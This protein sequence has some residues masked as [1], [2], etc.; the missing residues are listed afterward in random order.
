MQNESFTGHYIFKLLLFEVLLNCSVLLFVWQGDAGLCRTS[1]GLVW[2]C[3][4]SAVTLTGSCSVTPTQPAELD[5]GDAVTPGI[6]TGTPT[7]TTNT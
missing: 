2:F 4:S 7:Y 6:Y 3:D 1:L 5:L